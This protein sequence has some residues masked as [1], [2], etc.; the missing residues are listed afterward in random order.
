MADEI[1]TECDVWAE[2]IYQYSPDTT[3][4]DILTVFDDLNNSFIVKSHE[5]SDKMGEMVEEIGSE[6]L[7]DDLAINNGEEAMTYTF[8]A[9]MLANVNS[10]VKTELYNSRASCHMSPY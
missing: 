5:P 10:T 3:V 7:S 2:D 8:A 1:S 6:S 4:D 9:T